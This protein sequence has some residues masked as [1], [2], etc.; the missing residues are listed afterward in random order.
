MISVVVGVTVV[1]GVSVV[2][3][4]NMSH[5]GAVPLHLGWDGSS[6]VPL[7]RASLTAC[8]S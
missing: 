5:M 2:V 7:A 4:L 1:V 6:S 8:N 3:G